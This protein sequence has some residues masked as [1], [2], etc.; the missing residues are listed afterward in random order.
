M[1]AGCGGM[2]RAASCLWLAK[3]VQLC[4]ITTVLWAST[5]A[6][7]SSPRSKDSQERDGSPAALP[8]KKLVRIEGMK[9]STMTAGKERYQGSPG[10]TA[11]GTRRLR[12]EQG[13]ERGQDAATH[14]WALCRRGE[15]VEGAITPSSTA[16]VT[17]WVPANRQRLDGGTDEHLSP[18]CH[19]DE[20]VT[21]AVG[22]LASPS[23]RKDHPRVG[24]N[25]KSNRVSTQS[26]FRTSACRASPEPFT[27]SASTH[28]LRQ[29][30]IHDRC[31]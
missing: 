13:M 9:G 28:P 16:P 25:L 17:P 3:L 26:G 5:H 22:E 24:I 12:R 6:G 1:E 11:A 10:R 14:R 18:S 4:H 29:A 23:V 7:G 2:R 21:E 20:L 15:W 19:C 31:A 27:P 8:A 30:A